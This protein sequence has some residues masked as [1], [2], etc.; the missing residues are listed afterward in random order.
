MACFSVTWSNK[1]ENIST[2]WS[3]D[4]KLITFTSGNIKGSDHCYIGDLGKI[5]GWSKT[6]LIGCIG[7]VIGFH[8]NLMDEETSYIHQYLMTKWA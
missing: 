1:G 4:E 5:T 2:C 6:H 8:K 3:N 7:E